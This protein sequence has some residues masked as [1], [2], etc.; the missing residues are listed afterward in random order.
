MRGGALGDP[1]PRRCQLP[2][3]RAPAAAAGF[4]CSWVWGAMLLRLRPGEQPPATVLLMQSSLGEASTDRPAR[5]RCGGSG[6]G[7][8]T[9]HLPSGRHQREPRRVHADPTAH[10]LRPSV[11]RI[12]A[13]AGGPATQRASRVSGC[14]GPGPPPGLDHGCSAGLQLSPR[15]MRREENIPSASVPRLGSTIS[16]ARPPPL[17]TAPPSSPGPSPAVPGP[18]VL[19]PECWSRQALCTRRS[20]FLSTRRQ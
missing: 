9:L 7:R 3:H 5:E 19:P 20:P 1:G 6:I 11:L 2:S 10:W 17:L 12:P 13:C 18:E 14:V 8:F 15:V 16:V 4:L